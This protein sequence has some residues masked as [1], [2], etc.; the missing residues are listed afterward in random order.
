M[1]SREITQDNDKKCS[2]VWGEKDP[3][4]PVCFIC[5]ATTWS[6]NSEQNRFKGN[7]LYSHLHP[8]LPI[9]VTESE[10]FNNLFFFWTTLVE[11][12]CI[13]NSF[14]TYLVVTYGCCFYSLRQSQSKYFNVY[15]S[16]EFSQSKNWIML[17]CVFISQAWHPFW[18]HVSFWL[19]SRADFK[20]SFLCHWIKAVKSKTFCSY[21]EPF[22]IWVVVCYFPISKG[23]WLKYA[24]SF[25]VFSYHEP[26]AILHPGF[27]LISP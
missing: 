2:S 12:F 16:N 23:S 3:D 17:L 20:L 15:L 24:C 10:D 22:K 11:T 25:G 19:R 1:P 9:N 6:E 27:K 13:Y 18:I 21:Y 14:T 7:S 8:I 5:C 26:G 4:Q